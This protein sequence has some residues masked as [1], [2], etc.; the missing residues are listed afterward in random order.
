[1]AFLGYLSNIHKHFLNNINERQEYLFLPPT[2]GEK[3]TSDAMFEQIY[4]NLMIEKNRRTF[5]TNWNVTKQFKCESI[6]KV[7]QKKGDFTYFTPAVFWH[8]RKHTKEELV[9]LTCIILDFDF[10][11]DGTS[12]SYTNDELASMLINEFDAPPNF[13]WDTESKGNKQAGYLIEPMTGTMNSIYL[14][15]AI[16]KRMAI[17][18]GADFNS[19]DAVHLFRIPK[20]ALY[21]YT[22]EVY[23][24]EDFSF[25]LENEEINQML[26]KER[27][28]FK[29]IVSFT[30]HQILNHKSIQTLLNADFSGSRNHA[31]FTIALLY[32]ALGKDKEEV[33]ELLNGDWFKKV[34]EDA[35]TRYLRREITDSVKSAYSGKYSGPS[36]EW[37]YTLTGEEFPFNLWKSSYIKKA[38]SER[39]YKKGEEVRLKIIA[40]VRENTGQTIQQKEL[41]EL[42]E[43]PYRTL[44]LQLKNLKDEGVITFNTQKGRHSAGTSFTYIPNKTFEIEYDNKLK[45]ELEY[46]PEIEE[47]KA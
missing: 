2:T 15:E 32:Y 45:R 20:K 38:D 16:V 47:K 28:Q 40:W 9:W 37:I 30:E 17:L 25:V 13:I 4:R 46:Y 10:S 31:A 39:K 42:L 14:W 44:Q 8:H 3:V 12:R 6:E 18:T 7:L 1:M 36:K 19:T 35:S 43:V 22:N 21:Q 23:D 24:I 29:N 41:A 34:N 5:L 26:E 33:K 27:K 11:K